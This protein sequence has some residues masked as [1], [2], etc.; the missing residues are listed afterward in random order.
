MVNELLKIGKSN[1]MTSE[2]LI[3]TLKLSGTR[4]LVSIVQKERQ[5]GAVI[6]STC[7]N[8]GGYYLPETE[9]ELKEFIKSMDRRKS[10]LDKSTASARKELKRLR[11]IA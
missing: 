2:E 10:E 8:G 4:E 9:Q 1:I 11:E 5:Q 6:L 3:N 7:G